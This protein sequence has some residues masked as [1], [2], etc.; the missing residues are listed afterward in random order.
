MEAVKINESDYLLY[1][2]V[3]WACK[4]FFGEQQILSNERRRCYENETSEVTVIKINLMW[5]VVLE[6]M[7]TMELN[8]LVV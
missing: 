1:H 6:L 4:G 3:L 2:W 8:D 5:S 7:D